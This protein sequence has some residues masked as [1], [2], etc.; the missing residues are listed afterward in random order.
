MRTRPSPSSPSPSTLSLLAL[1]GLALGLAAALAPPAAAGELAGV[2][3]PDRETAGGREL[4][5]NGMGLR[6]KLFIKVYVGG[7]YLPER[8][9]S[10][11]RVLEADAPRVMVMHFLYGVSKDQ[12]CD[13]WNEGLE[14]NTPNAPAEVERD[15]QTLCGWMEAIEKG[16]QMRFTYVPGTGTT[17]A[18]KGRDKGTIAGKAFAD[19]LLACWIGPDP[20]PG[21]GFKK[22]LLG[23]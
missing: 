12:M 17:V 2:T 13:A 4:A 14:D 18:V 7:L 6:S 1:G 20:G 11:E 19:A 3:L 10:A 21:E 9:T 22:A 5:L 8:Q 16:E 23:G 15:F